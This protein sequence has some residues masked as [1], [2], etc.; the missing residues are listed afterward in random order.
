MSP[1]VTSKLLDVVGMF[2]EKGLFGNVEIIF[3]PLD[4][5]YTQAFDLPLLNFVQVNFSSS[6]FGRYFAREVVCIS[7]DKE[8]VEKMKEL[9]RASYR[10]ILI[11]IRKETS[12]KISFSFL[13]SKRKSIQMFDVN[14]SLGRQ[15]TPGEYVD[16]SELF[17]LSLANPSRLG[18]DGMKIGGLH[19]FRRDDTTVS[20]RFNGRNRNHP[21]TSYSVTYDAIDKLR[22]A[23]EDG[24]TM[25]KMG[26]DNNSDPYDTLF[27]CSLKNAT[28]KGYAA[29]ISE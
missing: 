15:F 27:V 12:D 23:I 25:V 13:D 3:T 16:H 21:V 10:K 4:G 2:E 26:I 8:L 1:E 19:I 18:A 11:S 5:V 6:F 29:T 20:V 17:P 9:S 14:R 24:E 22:R 7:F 28:I